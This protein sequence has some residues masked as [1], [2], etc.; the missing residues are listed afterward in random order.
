MIIPLLVLF[1]G[2]QSQQELEARLQQ[3]QQEVDSLN[4]K[5]T[6]LTRTVQQQ[7]Q[8]LRRPFC[9]AELRAVGANAS[10]AVSAE[11]VV[12]INLYS[13]VSKPANTCLPA[14]VR[15][16]ASYLDAFDNLICSGV[17]ENVA[18][19]SNFIQSVNLFIRPW[20]LQEFVRWRNEPPQT[21]SGFRRLSCV[22]PEGLA[23][24]NNE[25]LLRVRNVHIRITVLPLGG[26][27]S[28]VEANLSL[29]R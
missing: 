22:D 24:V 25:A 4:A 1:L 7:D 27:I 28:T 18:T 9:S 29:K 23:E 3:K 13:T 2:F 6:D 14:E 10:G 26:G 8:E 16:A 17:V 19:Q 20:N 11:A 21:N 15:V 5:V 12:P